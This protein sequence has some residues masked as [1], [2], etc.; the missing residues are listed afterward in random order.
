[1][2]SRPTLEQRAADIAAKARTQLPVDERRLGALIDREL[3]RTWYRM[4][5][6]DGSAFD[7]SF[8]PDVSPAE[9]RAWYP[10]C[11]VTPA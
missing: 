2:S 11:E 8:N 10:D 7:V 1:M 6:P 4:T 3:K 9:A 5:R